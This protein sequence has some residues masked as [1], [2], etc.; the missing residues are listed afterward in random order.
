MQNSMAQ[1]LMDI[2]NEVIEE[3]ENIMGHEA[4]THT[5]SEGSH[6]GIKHKNAALNNSIS[7][8]TTVLMTNNASKPR[9]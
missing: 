4:I 5:P 6:V 2:H 3:E 9:E 1:Q 8:G 7:K